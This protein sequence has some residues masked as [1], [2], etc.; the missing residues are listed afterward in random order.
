[1]LA[2]CASGD[3]GKVSQKEGQTDP[4][5]SAQNTK[6]SRQG[7]DTAQNS[8]D[9]DVLSYNG[10]AVNQGRVLTIGFSQ[11]GAESDWRMASTDSLQSAFSSANGYNLIYSD[12][13][14]KQENQIKAIREFIDQDVDYILLDPIT[15]DGWDSSLQEAKEAGIPVI[16]Y[17]RRVNVSDSSLYTAWI[18]S[19][20]LLEGKKACAWLKKFLQVKGISGD[21]NIVDIQGTMGSTAQIGR[22]QALMEAVSDNE[23][24]HV[25]AQSSGDFTTAKGK[26]VMEDIIAQYGHDIDVVY[27]ENDNEAYGVTDALESAGYSVG[28]NINLGQVMVM[29]FDSTKNALKMTLSGEI[30]VNT[31]CN[32]LYGPVLTQMVQTLKKGGTLQRET[33]IDE[34]QFSAMPG[35]SSVYV[36]GLPYEVTQITQKTLDGRKY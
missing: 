20:F 4:A 3:Q 19:D 12:A 7:D 26:E 8:A 34:G 10:V 27:C 23:N 28:S 31:E 6:N 2:G 14:Q 17:D 33:Y 11:I 22:T 25:I 32:P 5:S 30:S 36:D 1:M 13:Q 16:I 18:G 24:W 35:I 15:E 29:S 21:I 9:D